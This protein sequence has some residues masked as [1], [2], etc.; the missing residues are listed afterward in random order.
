MISKAGKEQKDA[1]IFEHIYRKY[2]AED[3]NDCVGAAF[4]RLPNVVN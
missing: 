2:A 4:Q 3:S 1:S